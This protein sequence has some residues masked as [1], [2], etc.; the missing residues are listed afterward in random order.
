M[1]SLLTDT[2]TERS[3]ILRL[4]TGCALGGIGLAILSGVVLMLIMRDPLYFFIPP[5]GPGFLRPG[6]LTPSYVQHEASQMALLQNNW[7]AETLPHVQAAFRQLLDPSLRKAYDEKTVPEERKVVKE[8]KI[9][10]SQC[11]VTGVDVL[12]SQGQKR[13]VLVHA[14]HT[15]YIGSTPSSEA[16]T[17]DL[18]LEP[19]TSTGRPHGLKIMSI[20]QSHPLKIVGR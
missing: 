13:R 18:G 9:V 6:E 3:L 11:V 10:L 14:V 1:A 16:V 7:T 17:I 19:D 4:A 20:K 5:T 8:S 15:L 2:A 12:K